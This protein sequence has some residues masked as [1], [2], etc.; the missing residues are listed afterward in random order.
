MFFLI[1]TVLIIFLFFS[2]EV[3][4]KRNLRTMFNVKFFKQYL[5]RHGRHISWKLYMN[6]QAIHQMKWKIIW[7]KLLLG[8]NNGS[9]ATWKVVNNS[10]GAQK[11]SF[12]NVSTSFVLQKQVEDV[13]SALFQD[14]LSFSCKFKGCALFYFIK[15]INDI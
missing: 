13:F 15:N 11:T 2:T 8:L 6:F 14:V 12:V 10:H 5:K 3:T 4:A 1:E 7:R 9:K